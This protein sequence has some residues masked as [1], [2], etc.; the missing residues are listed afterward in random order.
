MV[1]SAPTNIG[2]HPAD[3]EQADAPTSPVVREARGLK[4]RSIGAGDGVGL[5]PSGYLRFDT[6]ADGPG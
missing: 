5:Q 4:A 6:W 1:V 2:R 3:Q